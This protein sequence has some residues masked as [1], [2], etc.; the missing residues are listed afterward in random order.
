MTAWVRTH[1]V[2]CA[3]CA[4]GAVLRALAQVGFEPAL[5]FFDSFTYLE[6]AFGPRPDTARPLGYSVLVLRPLLLLHNLAHQ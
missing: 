3:L 5:F 1:W 2:F 4:A 6:D